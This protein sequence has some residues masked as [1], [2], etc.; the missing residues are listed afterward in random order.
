MRSLLF[1]G[2]MVQSRRC[3]GLHYE[4]TVLTCHLWLDFV[5]Q[6]PQPTDRKGSL[7]LKWHRKTTPSGHNRVRGG[8]KSCVTKG[9]TAFLP[10]IKQKSATKKH[11]QNKHG[12]NFS[13]WPQQTTWHQ[14]P[15]SPQPSPPH[16]AVLQQLRGLA[17]WFYKQSFLINSC[18][19]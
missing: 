19:P 2:F 4:T 12:G 10:V 14:L 16:R 17:S 3:D 5:K 13:N 18:R 15:Q 9:H 6:C 8:H 1:Q 7:W 11:R